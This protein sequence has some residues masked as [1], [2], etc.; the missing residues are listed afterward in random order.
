M[1]VLITTLLI[2]ILPLLLIAY[3]VKKLAQ[4]PK[5]KEVKSRNP[6]YTLYLVL[7]LIFAPSMF[8]SILFSNSQ[9]I[10]ECNKM[11]DL[12]IYKTKTL[13]SDFVVEE[14]YKISDIKSMSYNHY[15]V[16]KTTKRK[17]RE[18]TKTHDEYNITI[19]TN[20]GTYETKIMFKN[21]NRAD[22]ELQKWGQYLINDEVLYKAAIKEN[23]KVNIILL[24]VFGAVFLFCFYQLI[25]VHIMRYVKKKKSE[26]V[27]EEKPNQT[28]M[29]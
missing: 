13:V 7:L 9:E 23:T 18:T 17:G 26:K 20:S 11:Q 14:E 22:Q 15:I 21:K 5:D 1:A 16:T 2:S 28:I 8:F 4:K 10:F 19:E 27:K 12:C 25:G 6:K 3:I 24:I 29:R